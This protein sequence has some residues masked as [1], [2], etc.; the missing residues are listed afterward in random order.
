MQYQDVSMGKNFFMWARENRYVIAV[1]VLVALA[2]FGLG[3]LSV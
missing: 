3:R 1:L 2:A